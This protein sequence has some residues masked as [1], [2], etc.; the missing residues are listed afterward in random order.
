MCGIVGWVDFTT[1]LKDKKNVIEEMNEQLRR[2]GPDAKGYFV[3]QN[4]ILGHRRLIVIDPAGGQQ[5]MEITFNAK[6]Y[7]ITYNGEIYN[8]QEVKSKLK[9]LGYN[10][11]TT[12]D[13][14][15]I[16]ASYAAFGKECVK[17]LN[18]IFAFAIWDKKSVFIARDRLGVKPLFYAHIGNSLLFASEIKSFLKHPYIKSEIDLV[19]LAEVLLI[20]PARTPGIGVFKNIKELKAGNWLY[21]DKEGLTTKVY[22]ELQSFQ[23][24]DDFNTTVIN[25]KELFTNAV[26]QQLISDVPVGTMLSGG[27]DSSSITYVASKYFEKEKKEKLAT[28]SIDYKDNEKYF[29]PNEFQPNSDKEYIDIM[30]KYLQTKHLEISITTTDLI[31]S[32]TEALIARDLPGMADI[33]SSLLLFCKE[34]KERVTVVLSGECADE[35]FGGYPWF[36][37]EDLINETTFPW[38]RFLK[39]RTYFLREDII[40]KIN[41]FEY[42]NSRYQEALSEVPRFADESTL[43][44]RIREIF[45]ISITRWMPTLLD[46]KDRMSMYSG[47][48]VRVP[49][50]DHNLVEYVFNIPWSMKNHQNREKSIFRI[51]MQDLLPSKI[52][53]RKKSP[54]PKTHNPMYLQ[55]MQKKILELLKNLNKEPIFE[56]IDNKKLETFVNKDLKKENIPWFGQ[57]MNVPSLLAFFFQLN[58]WLKKYNIKIDLN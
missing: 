34:I 17:Y 15:V 4:A 31:N 11:K 44:A 52:T 45:Y 22:W 37:R 13:T 20:A 39:N 35:I 54:Y 1:N 30:V 14:E 19:G 9:N 25:I 21:F 23:H 38:S 42:V 56:I 47:L 48:E 53:K 57:L 32:L 2:R 16:V 18:G 28:F 40:E 41:P 10:F 26:E 8:M 5:P 46:R 33:D 43:E 6:K 27:I 29:R 36:H 55:T 58:N 7:V 24:I 50:C 3:C 51:A 49:F 12:S